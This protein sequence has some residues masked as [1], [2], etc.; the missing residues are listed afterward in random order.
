[1]KFLVFEV[2]SRRSQSA[3]ASSQSCKPI[4]QLPMNPVF[5]SRPR[6]PRND[7][8]REAKV[9][10]FLVRACMVMFLTF[11][12]AGCGGG[13]GGQSSGPIEDGPEDPEIPEEPQDPG[14]PEDP[15]PPEP[16]IAYTISTVVPGGGGT[17]FPATLSVSPQ[18]VAAFTVA[19]APNYAVGGV[20]GCGGSLAGD[21]YTTEA[22]TADCT[23]TAS[24]I[25]IANIAPILTSDLQL[26]VGDEGRLL[27]SSN[28]AD[29]EES[30]TGVQVRLN[31]VTRGGD[32]FV[33]VGDE[34]I[35]L[36]SRDGLSWEQRPSSSTSILNSIAWG[37]DRFIAVGE[38]GTILVSEDGLVWVHAVSGV[39]TDLSKI[40]WANGRFVAVGDGS[41]NG[42]VLSSADGGT[43]QMHRTA[44]S[45]DT[46][47]FYNAIAWGNAG[48]IAVGTFAV[49]DCVGCGASRIARRSMDL[50]DWETL[51]VP[52]PAGSVT[53]LTHIDWDG[54][55][56]LA[57]GRA[58][59]A[60]D[61][62]DVI[63]TSSNGVD[64]QTT[65][66]SE[67]Q[68]FSDVDWW[69]DRNWFAVDAA[70][71]VSASE[72]GE[73]W[74][75]QASLGIPLRAIFVNGLPEIATVGAEFRF[76]PVARDQDGDALLFSVDN[77]PEWANFDEHT[78]TLWGT[79]SV[80]DIG[81]AGG[82]VISVTD[83]F[84]TA[85]LLP[86]DLVVTQSPLTKPTISGTPAVEVMHGEEYRF[87]PQASD[88]DGDDLS[89]FIEN[90]PAWA[91]FDAATGVLSGIPPIEA[92]GV[93]GGIAI[94]VFDGKEAVALPAFQIE[95]RNRAPAIGNGLWLAAGIDGIYASRNLS[96]WDLVQPGD[97]FSS[98]RLAWNGL[99]F[100]MVQGNGPVFASDDARSWQTYATGLNMR[101]V[102]GDNG[103]FVAVGAYFEDGDGFHDA[104]FRS[105]DGEAWSVVDIGGSVSRIATDGSRYIALGQD[106][107]GFIIAHASDDGLTWDTHVTDFQGSI[108]DVVWDGDRFVAVG[109]NLVIASTEGGEWT[110]LHVP[111]THTPMRAIAWNGAR[112]L[113]V[114]ESVSTG[115]VPG[116]PTTRDAVVLS[117]ENAVDWDRMEFP[118]E[119]V[120][121]T[122]AGG[123]ISTC[124]QQTV[125]A[126]LRTIEWDGLQFAAMGVKDVVRSTDGASVV[127]ASGD[128]VANINHLI[129]RPGL[130]SYSVAVG[131]NF[132][133]EPFASD[134]DGDALIFSVDG[135]PI[136]ADFDEAT[137]IL[138]GTPGAGDIGFTDHVT[139]SV[140]DTVDTVS[141]PVLE[142]SVVAA[143]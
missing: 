126:G 73:Q 50:A 4:V 77:L 18:N 78:G 48:Y 29:W 89:F 94:S 63:A 138:S 110:A 109:D 72:D 41:V 17:L 23:I 13:G 5:R 128:D 137:G 2:F 142:I 134:A 106:G 45:G 71:S 111:E 82:I 141:L 118:T 22:I 7:P 12:L 81:V 68:S 67:A 133:L 57:R 16:P 79:P 123:T 11:L 101:D 55:R 46:G 33:A 44:G 52:F 30:D 21:V 121:V 120:C 125:P 129:A 24:F 96:V 6:L 27:A 66:L 64:W 75:P 97:G 86:F 58:V 35:V 140:T 127:A 112:Y 54:A 19:A 95:V 14:A 108:N 116:T 10:L 15:E 119:S 84:D 105:D 42:S 3:W 38:S 88:P 131:E 34:G 70:G 65:V 103:L 115:P 135:L 47:V 124:R 80:A 85:S 91:D 76:T 139:I 98:P 107:E 136:W 102:V 104:V 53:S 74:T 31:D 83:G 122:S 39:S 117:S 87:E 28:G 1:M 113:I 100:V 132:S 51:T 40:I 49:P 9:V 93:H 32:L 59:Q 92:T 26:V 37:N 69:S 130:E 36:A 61:S 56:Y 90:R 20:T 62:S 99:R 25:R 43:W 60:L 114:G 143:P 8:L